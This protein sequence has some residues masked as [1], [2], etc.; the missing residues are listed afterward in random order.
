LGIRPSVKVNKKLSLAIP[1]KA[2][3]SLKDY[4]EGPT[5]SNKFGYLDT[6]LIAS[7]PFTS[8]KTS[9][10]VHGGV[11]ILSFGDN[12]KLLNHGDRVKPVASIGLGFTY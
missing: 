12:L 9:W 10:D 2:G 7:V 5:G 3:L 4:Y 6:G 8:G 11:D 1:V